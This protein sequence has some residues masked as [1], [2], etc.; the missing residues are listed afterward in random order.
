MRTKTRVL[1]VVFPV[2]ALV[3]GAC[4]GSAKTESPASTSSSTSTTTVAPATT[5]SS[6]TTAPAADTATA[7]WP[8]ASTTL[9]FRDPVAATTSFAVD[10][11]HMVNPVVGA[12]QQG[13]SRSGEVEV[14]PRTN[15]P[16]TT[17]FV[18]QLG[19]D[20]TW[21][22][23]GAATPEIQ[24]TEPAAL[25]TI[26]SPVRLAGQSTAFEATVNVSIR[27]DGGATPLAETFVM[28]GANGTMGP[29]A[30]SVAFS[31]PTQPAGAIVLYQISS[32]SGHVTEASVIRVKFAGS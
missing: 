11:L 19:T 22:V 4:G 7:V 15:G 5:A 20:S 18:R 26:S 25:A 31:A 6:P 2:L 17:V 8:V 3:A 24:L 14:R 13:D 29:F 10:F 28:G 9:R 16:V 1:L 21:W 30:K 12:F 27:E 32:E 23:L